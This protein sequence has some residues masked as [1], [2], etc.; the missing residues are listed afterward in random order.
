MKAQYVT[1]SNGTTTESG[2]YSDGVDGGESSSYEWNFDA[3]GNMTSGEEVADQLH[4]HM[5]LTGRLREL[6]QMLVV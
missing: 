6:R 5:V 1:N 2:K 3:A 4:T